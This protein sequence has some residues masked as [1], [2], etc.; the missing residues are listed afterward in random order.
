[1]FFYFFVVRHGV[2]RYLNSTSYKYLAQKAASSTH[3]RR[4]SL[5]NLLGVSA[6]AMSAIAVLVFIV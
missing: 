3:I 2:S 4:G 5:K 1:M 6:T